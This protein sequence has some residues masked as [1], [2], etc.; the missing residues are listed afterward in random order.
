MTVRCHAVDC[1]RG[2]R[3]FGRPTSILWL[4]VQ[5]SAARENL[6]VQLALTKLQEAE[7]QLRAHQDSLATALSKNEA[8]LLREA[9]L[10][11]QLAKAKVRKPECPD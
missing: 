4:P 7:A 2:I 9:E 10:E 1:S 6:E 8:A 3:R 5:A 11:Q